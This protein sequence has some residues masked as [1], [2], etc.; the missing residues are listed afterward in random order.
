MIMFMFSKKNEFSYNEN[1]YLQKFPNFT[2]EKL[3]NN[4]FLNKLSNY[5]SDYFPFREQLINIRTNTFFPKLC[6]FLISF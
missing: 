3:I 6:D 2:F 5:F 4:E 1:R